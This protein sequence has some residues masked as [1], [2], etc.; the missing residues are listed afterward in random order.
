MY[1]IDLYHLHLLDVVRLWSNGFYLQKS[2]CLLQNSV[3]T[4]NEREEIR[5]QLVKMEGI[6]C[7][8]MKTYYGKN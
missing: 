3:L 8:A 2:A 1:R 6:N 5:K 4:G 7:E